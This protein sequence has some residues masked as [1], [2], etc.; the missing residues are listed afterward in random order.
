MHLPEIELVPE[1]RVTSSHLDVCKR[2]VHKSAHDSQAADCPLRTDEEADQGRHQVLH[3][4]WM[5]DQVV[6]KDTLAEVSPWLYTDRQ[7][8]NISKS[9][10]SPALLG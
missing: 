10:V 2:D 6:V 9:S 8:L 1:L 3:S 7:H 5:F 4:Q